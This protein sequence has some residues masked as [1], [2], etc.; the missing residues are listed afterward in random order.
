M[1]INAKDVQVTGRKHEQKLYRSHSQY[2]G[3]LK[4]VPYAVLAK[5]DPGAVR[6]FLSFSQAC[7][8]KR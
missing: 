6:F 4:E 2:P 3:G 5:K 1:V 7:M 8:I